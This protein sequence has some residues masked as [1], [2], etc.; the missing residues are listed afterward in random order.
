MGGWVRE[1]GKG[2]RR[3]H[4]SWSSGHRVCGRRGGHIPR[5]QFHN[6]SL[7]E[8]MCLYS[9]RR[10]W[11]GRGGREGPDGSY[12]RQSLKAQSIVDSKCSC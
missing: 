8:P 1:E 3:Q 12:I 9:G 4:L 11:E 6:R 2:C 5:I 10:E 7:S